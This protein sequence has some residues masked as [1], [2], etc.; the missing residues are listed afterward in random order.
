MK[1]Y[2]PSRPMY[3]VVFVRKDGIDFAS[4][5]DAADILADPPEW[6]ELEDYFL[7]HYSAV[8]DALR[9]LATERYEVA[10]RE[11]ALPSP[12]PRAVFDQQDALYLPAAGF[13][14]FDRMGPTLTLYHLRAP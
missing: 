3:D 6:L 2:D 12:S 7:D 1:W 9:R 11:L 10:H 14:D 5:R 4:Q 13:S 8:P